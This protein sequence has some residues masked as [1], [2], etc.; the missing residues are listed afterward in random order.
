MKY[1][2]Y[3]AIL[4]LFIAFTGSAEAQRMYAP[5]L[6]APIPNDVSIGS[7]TAGKNLT[8]NATQT[9]IF[10]FDEANVNED[11]VTWTMTGAG[12]LVHVTGNTTALTAT[13][14]EAIVAGTTYPVTITGTGSGGTA[15]YTLGG[16]AGT[17]IAASGAIAIE[18]FITASTTGAFIITPA[19]GCTV[20]ITSITIGKS[21]DATGDLTVGGNATFKSPITISGIGG[22]A[23]IPL[24][25]LGNRVGIHSYNSSSLGV[26]F[27]SSLSYILAW[28][29]FN[30]MSDTATIK[31]GSS[32]DTII[33]RDAANIL[34]LRNSTAQNKLRV[35]NTWT[36]A[37]NYEYGALTGVAGASINLT[38]E[39]AGT[40]GDN[41]DIVLTPAG[42][43]AVNIP[44]RTTSHGATEAVAAATMYG[45]IHQITGNYTVTLPAAVVGMS[46][47]FRASSAAA[48]SVD[49]N[50][51]DHFEDYE[52]TA[53]DAGDKLTSSG[54]KN[55]WIDI[56]CESANTWI[57]RRQ[58]G[59][60][61][62][63]GA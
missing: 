46:A 38:A 23:S 47:T 30:I 19:S 50:A 6:A 54:V 52:G 36:D 1:I 44:V 29:A 42:T 16:V 35:A 14:T 41:L 7:T 57:V 58:G 43:G 51:A 2:K 12:A 5:S 33:T 3:L 4:I 63:G 21:V 48:F 56:Y 59:V 39:T 17:T 25:N 34:A 28:G 9:S 15:T 20:S 27:S 31:L 26:T 55:E 18:D 13:T 45:N 32:S 40:G 8:V 22:S 60:I 11:D 53:L 62:D 10:T 24:I 61:I 37:S 49:T